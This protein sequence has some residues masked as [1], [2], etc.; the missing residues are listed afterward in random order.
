M[1][2]METSDERDLMAAEY[3]LGVLDSGEYAVAKA[4]YAQDAEFA[5][6]VHRWQHRFSPLYHEVE[7]EEVPSAL[8]SRVTGGT[9]LQVARLVRHVAAWRAGAIAA[10]ALAATLAAVLVV[11]PTKVA[12]PQVVTRVEVAPPEPTTFAQLIEKDGKATVMARFE[13]ATAQ[14]RV[15]ASNIPQAGGTPELWVI[16]DG[17]APKS[18]G[19]IDRAH[20]ATLAI[21]GDVRP[22]LHAGATLAVTLEDA[23]TAPHAAPTGAI[24]ASGTIARL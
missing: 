3:A 9:R 5:A 4:R 20:E 23:A 7:E 8:W 10:T 13:P 22:L 15:R 18:L 2:E 11:Q 14:L 16:A 24:L 17:D 19:L 12:P 1:T 21:G 6:A